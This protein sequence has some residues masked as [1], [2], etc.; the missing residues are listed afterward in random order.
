GASPTAPP[1]EDSEPEPAPSGL[2]NPLARFQ[3]ADKA[4][5]P[6]VPPRPRP[7]FGNRDWVIGID[8]QA[9]AVVLLPTGAKVT[10]ASLTPR[11]DKN[12]L[13]DAVER[14][15]A[16][17]QATVRPGEPPYRPQIRFLVH[18]DGL[19]TYYLAYPALEGMRLPMTRENVEPPVDQK[20]H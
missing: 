13:Q 2:P 3:T 9:E 7:L 11:S 12:P 6:A 14:L 10:T 18:P 19:R 1:P 15:I 5:P 20:K 17:R 8:C 4:K 16:R